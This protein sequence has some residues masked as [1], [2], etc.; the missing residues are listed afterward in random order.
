MSARKPV[1]ATR[2]WKCDPGKKT[3]TTRPKVRSS[4]KETGVGMIHQ[5]AEQKEAGGRAQ[6]H[7]VG[8]SSTNWV[9]GRDQCKME[10]GAPLF[11]SY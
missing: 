9:M 5:G 2:C 8:P 6:G 4:P 7:L 3:M 1:K 11:E 10:S